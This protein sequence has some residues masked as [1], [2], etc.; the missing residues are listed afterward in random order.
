MRRYARNR[1]VVDTFL[2]QPCVDC[3]ESFP[4]EIMVCDHVRGVKEFTISRKLATYSTARIE[5]ELE[6]CDPRCPTHHALRHHIEG[7]FKQLAL[8]AAG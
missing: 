5:A 4:P 2:S 1:A 8:A 3:G 6:K 7:T